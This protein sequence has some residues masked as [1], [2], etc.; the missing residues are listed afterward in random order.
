ML[1]FVI[2]TTNVRPASGFEFD[3]TA[4][5]CHIL[6]E[7]NTENINL[8][9]LH[10]PMTKQ[11]ILAVR[12]TGCWLQNWT[13]SERLRPRH[14]QHNHQRTR[15]LLSGVQFHQNFMH[16]F[17]VHSSQK[18]TDSLAVFFCTFAIWAY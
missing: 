6:F 4:L 1:Y 14:P 12:T 3:M 7:L 18:K 5:E 10:M 11:F 8:T 9:F 15:P 17:Y 16:N 2:N 13:N